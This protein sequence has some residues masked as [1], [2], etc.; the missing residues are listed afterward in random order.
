[1]ILFELFFASVSIFLILKSFSNIFKFNFL[2]K[3]LLAD[4]CCDFFNKYLTFTIEKCYFDFYSKIINGIKTMKNSKDRSMEI[5]E[6]L[7]G[8]II[9][10][11]Y[12]EKYFNSD[13]TKNIFHDI[14]K[15]NSV[16][17]NV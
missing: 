8:D 4:S 16:L 11:M 7:L 3:I 13:G 14:N 15:F 10:K 2:F 1:M 12:V 9:G 6:N 17:N 5:T